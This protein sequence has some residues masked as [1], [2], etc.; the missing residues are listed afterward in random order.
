M[1]MQN[2]PFYHVKKHTLLAV[3]GCVWLMAGINGARLGILAYRKL[4]V[5]SAFSILLSF[6]T[7]GAFG[8]MFY[9]MN[10]FF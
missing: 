1:G 8:F 9:K 3:A 7:F 6:L 5:V 10:F 2:T 4:D